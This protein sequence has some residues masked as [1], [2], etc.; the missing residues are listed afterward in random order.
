MLNKPTTTP[1][2]TNAGGAFRQRWA[3]GQ[4]GNENYLFLLICTLA[5][6]AT[7]WITWPLW[8]V[9]QSPINLPWI[10]SAPQIPFGLLM[11]VSLM[12][13]LISPREF[14]LGIHLAVLG[15]AI[16]ADQFRCQ[17]QVLWVAVL[18]IACVWDRTKP[19]CVWALVAL[20]LWAGIHKSVSAEWFGGNTLQ[21]LNQAGIAPA[22]DWCFGFAL[23]V[24][25]S[26]LAQG[27]WAILRPRGAAITC[28]LLHFGIAGFMLYIQWNLSVVPWNLCTG[29]VGA[30]LMS[31]TATR[32]HMLAV[33]A[34]A[35]GTGYRWLARSV[36]AALLILPAGFYTGHVRHCFA[37]ALYSGG[38]PLACI[39][40]LDGTVEELEGWDIVHVPFPHVHSAF[41]Q[42]FRLTGAP[43][44]KLHIRE[45][46]PWLSSR[47]YRLDDRGLPRE[48]SQQA[49][50]DTTATGD[51]SGIAL[52]DRVAIFELI[53]NG[54]SMK[55]RTADSMIFAISFKPEYFNPGLL[56]L[57]SGL[58]NVEE[59]QLQG[60]DVRNDDLKKMADLKKLEGIGL[61]KTPITVAGLEHLAKLKRLNLIEYKGQLYDSIRQ[62]MA[63]GD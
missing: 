9:R 26:E 8:E 18:M 49:F 20:W 47:Y 52:D 50:F 2:P 6:L 36:I 41:L 57:V 30:W 10:A 12:G 1:S 21:L 28:V 42:Y 58:P 33:P 29:I 5:Q 32:K 31:R 14:G 35:A 27:I 54:A 55:R 63:A 3:T 34:L 51:I 4:I 60:C 40:K 62:I 48:I 39:S 23:L 37:H 13:V 7:I 61:N 19:F 46:L 11:I 25:V 43:G 38:L 16:C 15:T 59:I 24:T 22:M 56:E 53:K 17:P 44:E 45:M